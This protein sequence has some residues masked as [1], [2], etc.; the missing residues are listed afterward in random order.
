MIDNNNRLFDRA[1]DSIT[2]IVGGW[3]PWTSKRKAW[4]RSI[5]A[6]TIYQSAMLEEEMKQVEGK[7]TEGDEKKRRYKVTV[8]YENF[9]NYHDIRQEGEWFVFYYNGIVV[10]FRHKDERIEHIIYDMDIEVDAKDQE[11]TQNIIKRN[12][13]YHICSFEVEELSEDK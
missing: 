3:W 10:T 11:D 1:Y 6:L 7:R 12:S 5:S 8:G 2:E 4:K 9:P 13:K